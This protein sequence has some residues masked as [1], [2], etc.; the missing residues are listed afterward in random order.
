VNNMSEKLSI[1][2]KIGFS[3]GDMAGNFV[4]Q[5][6]VLLL[7]FYYTDVY[8]LDAA[9]VTSIFLFV[10]IF[11]AITDPLMGALVDRTQ[12][13]WGKYR[14]YILWLAIPYAVASVL[15]FTVPNFGELGNTIY[16]YATY[17]ILMMLFTAINIPYFSL[18]SVITCDPEERV[19]LNSYRFVA[20]TAGGLIITACVI[21][22]AGILGGEDKATG[23]SQAMM[24]MAFISV[25]LFFICFASTKERVKPQNQGRKN[26]KGDIAQVLANG[27][28]RLLA[29]A[30][31]ILVT[32]Q[33][34]KGTMAAFY[35]NYYVDDAATLLALF[36]SVWMVGGML[37]SAFAKPLTSIFCKKKLW[38]SICVISAL[39]SALTFLIGSSNLVMIMIMQFFV[40]FFNQMMAPLIFSTMADVTDY[41]EL[42]N[43]N[44]LDGLISSLT[45]FS[46]KIGL[47][48]GGAVATYMLAVYGYQ[49]GGVAQ[50]KSTIEGVL[51]IFTIL[52]AIG[53]VLTA[54]VISSMKLSSEVVKENAEKLQLLRTST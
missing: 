15:V 25:I 13:K 39:L 27:Q 34:I 8:G 35:I 16:A 54:I 46:L 50:E 33:T 53:F 7:A 28:W 48:I 38:V 30:I 12:T 1:R 32:A 18:G 24:V 23:Y 22:L 44:R 20:A 49:S 51:T 29:I 45:I 21:P 5:S 4:Y 52:P 2:E 10:R 43:N 14:P 17:A 3:L 19:S 40:G 37:G 26:I 36:L 11:D 6:V 9:T 47:A 31:L 41:G 42:K